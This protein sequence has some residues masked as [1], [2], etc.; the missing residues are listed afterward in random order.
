MKNYSNWKI[1]DVRHVTHTFTEDDV[2]RFASLTGDANPLHVNRDYA[3]QSAAG[4]IV[5]HGMLAASYI[6]TL[7][8][9][10]I[11][12]PGALWSSFNVD[13][14]KII[15]IGDSIRFTA[16]VTAL[17]V[18]TKAMDLKI[19]GKHED[20]ETIYLNA[21]AR[22]MLMEK[23][24]KKKNEKTASQRIL[25]TG[26]SGAV[27]KTICAEL[28]KRGF[29][30]IA[31]GRD[32]NRLQRLCDEIGPQS[33]RFESVDLADRNELNQALSEVTKGEEIGGFVHAAAVPLKFVAVDD[34]NN[35]DELLAHWQVEVLAF[36]MIA[37][38]LIPHISQGGGIVAVLTQAIFDQP[39]A[40][41]SAYVSAK[42]A[43]LGL[44]KSIAVECRPKGVRCN[45]VSP[46]LIDT[47]YTAEMPMRVKQIEAASNP[48]RRLCQTEDVAEVVSFLLRPESNYI[49]GANVPITGGSRMP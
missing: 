3:E 21:K 18:A 11:P 46:N 35:H 13:W 37:Q 41:L 23:D 24:I 49:N 14:Q 1:G 29:E 2:K 33:C 7:I 28:V 19:I 10:K 9:M 6:S 5:V 22:V 48:S 26:A 31:W 25:V 44:V 17:Q 16:E 4:G 39:P 32:R 43:C 45:A 8:G 15:R 20:N 27:G 34:P 38:A 36:Q 30:V 12:G 47:P 42:Y 40:K